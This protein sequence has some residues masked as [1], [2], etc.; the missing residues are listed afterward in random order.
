MNLARFSGRS[1]VGLRATRRGAVRCPH[2]AAGLACPPLTSPMDLCINTSVNTEVHASPDARRK[3]VEL[4]A[5]NRRRG[6]VGG[7]G[8]HVDQKASHCGR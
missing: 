7:L 4:V 2:V 6:G 8:E 1:L 5:D 3:T